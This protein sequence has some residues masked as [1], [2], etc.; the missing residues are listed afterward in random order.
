MRTFLYGESITD[1]QSSLSVRFP[2][3]ICLASSF[4]F[5]CPSSAPTVKTLYIPDTMSVNVAFAF[6]VCFLRYSYVVSTVATDSI[7]SFVSAIYDHRF[8]FPLCN[9][10]SHSDNP[11]SNQSNPHGS[12]PSASPPLFLY[13]SYILS[14]VL[15]G[16][17][18]V[19]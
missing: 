3:L 10:H 14:C 9:A 6:Y 4:P 11:K 19:S 5:L 2:A 12:P 1:T 18:L 15:H 7:L 8:S 16:L 17:Q 13:S